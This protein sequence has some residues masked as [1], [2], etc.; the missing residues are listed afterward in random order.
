MGADGHISIYSLMK[1]EDKFGEKQT[2]DFLNFVLML[3]F[4]E[5]LR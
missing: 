1:F 4:D 3:H 5:K 2:E